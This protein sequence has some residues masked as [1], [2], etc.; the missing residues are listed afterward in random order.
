MVAEQYLYL[1]Y[2]YNFMKETLIRLLEEMREHIIEQLQNQDLS[3][4]EI[5]ELLDSL[6]QNKI[7]I[8]KLKSINDQ[9]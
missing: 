5:D 8:E 2:H 6:I 1:T 7:A 3:L 4:N 9:S